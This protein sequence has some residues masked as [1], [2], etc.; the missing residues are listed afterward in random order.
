LD[1]SSTFPQGFAD[2]PREQVETIKA[3]QLQVHWTNHVH[4]VLHGDTPSAR[5]QRH[6]VLDLPPSSLTPT[7]A[8]PSLS[9]TLAREYANKTSKT[10]RRDLVRL[11]ELGLIRIVDDKVLPEVE[12]MRAFFPRTRE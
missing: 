10:L 7:S 1:L 12:L 9:P 11:E 3:Q 4:G 6:L 5:R 2:S 8:I